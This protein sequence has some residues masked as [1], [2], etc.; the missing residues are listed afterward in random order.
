MAYS[1]YNPSGQGIYAEFRH[2]LDTLEDSALIARLQDY[3]PTGRPG[4][5]LRTLWN[6]YLA[7]FFLDLPHINAL[8]RR[9]HDDPTLREVCGFE[10]DGQLPH[11]ETVKLLRSSFSVALNTWG[12]SRPLYLVELVDHTRPLFRPAGIFLPKQI[13]KPGAL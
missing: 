9:L 4:W 12:V 3:R 10:E 13:E 8:I 1:N 7:S 6:T 2:L 5:H 11:T